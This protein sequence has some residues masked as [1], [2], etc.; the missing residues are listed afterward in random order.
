MR[1]RRGKRRPVGRAACST[2]RTAS[3]PGCA[4]RSAPRFP[5]IGVG[6]VMSRRRRARQARGRRR[7]GP[8]LH[9]LHLQRPGAGDG[10]GTRARRRLSDAGTLVPHDCG[11][12]LESIRRHGLRC[13]A[14]ARSAARTRRLRLAAGH[15][16][17]HGA[18]RPGQ[19]P[20][21]GRQ[22]PHPVARAQQGADR[23][24]L[25]GAQSSDVLARHLALEQAIA[26]EPARRSATAS[27]CSRTGRTPTPPCS[28]RSPRR[29]TASTWR[30]TSSR[31]TRSAALRRR[32]AS[33]SSAQG[34]QVN[35]IHDSVGTLGTP[36]EYFKRLSD[37][38]IN[39][40]EFNPVNPLA[41]KAGWDVNQR[42][43]RK[44]LV[45]DGRSGGPRRHQHQQ[46]LLERR[47]AARAAAC[48]GSRGGDKKSLPWRDTDLLI[49]GPVVAPLQKLFIETWQAQKGTPLAPRQY[50]PPLQARGKEVVRAIGSAPDEPFSQIYVTLISAINSA[51]TEILVT[52]AYFVPDPQLM[53]ALIDA[54]GARRRREADPAEHDRLVAGLPRR[55]R[56]TT[57]RCCAAASRSTSAGGPAARQ[58]RRHRRRLVDRGLDQP[59]LAQ[60]PAQ[61]GVDRRHSRHG[62]RRED[63]GSVRARPR[64][65][66]AD[67]ARGVA[68]PAGRDAGQ[69]NVRH[70]CG[71]TG[72]E[73]LRS[74]LAI[75]RAPPASLLSRCCSR[76]GCRIG[77]GRRHAAGAPRVA[78]GQARQQPVRPAAGARVAQTRAT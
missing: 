76:S 28:A 71:S 1:A 77:A 26:D 25:G 52:N 37:A 60:L 11:D 48:G 70:D 57:S 69:G 42:D 32:A 8:D 61:P 72:C 44:L 78:A 4:P 54:V 75:A 64:R 29:A 51:E 23:R 56:R 33:P 10:G 30:P 45:V 46:R 63:A 41:A 49:E 73:H 2:A 68:A 47:A 17:R 58:D 39:V 3:S 20:V 35:L 6:G 22:R 66:R 14:P 24:Q 53:E 36:K 43:H 18:G 59:R 9:R 67:H 19:R 31:T 12:R 74:R 65:V 16:A 21:P 7:P 34:V 62:F 5:I 38:G 55:P 13:V 15:H 40:L 50:F 27:S